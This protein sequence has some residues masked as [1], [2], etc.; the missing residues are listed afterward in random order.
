MSPAPIN[1]GGKHRGGVKRIALIAG[2][3]KLPL[4]FAERAK[5]QGDYIVSLGINDI[6]PPELESRV[7]KAFWGSIT[8]TKRALGILRDEK[9]THVVMTG[10][11]PKAVIFNRELHLNE[12][13][14]EIFRN[15]VDSKD[16]TIIKA[17]ALKLR[18]EGIS[19]MDPTP[20]FSELLPRKG[21]IS[22][23]PPT[24]DEWQDIKFGYKAAKRIA[25]MDIGQAVAIKKKMVLA[26]EAIEGT[27]KMIRRTGNLGTKNAVIVKVARPRQDMRFDVPTVGPETIDSM[28]AANAA[29]LAVEA[30]KT[31]VVDKAEIKRKADTAGIAVIA[32]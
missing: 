15:T 27:D 2:Q 8:D 1:P 12:D 4:I 28:I 20:Y 7:N 13:A 22:G 9:I 29:V 16:Y 21:L 32:V 18:K 10:K 17:V 19:V 31:L 14:S 11:I 5:S 26:V 24:N 3:G 25:G 23:R 30:R 6:T